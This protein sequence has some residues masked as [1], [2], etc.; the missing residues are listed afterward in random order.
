MNNETMI[1][2]ME[3]SLTTMKAAF[4]QSPMPSLEQRIEKLTKLRVALI[5]H[6]DQICE[7]MN[8]DYGQR[9]EQDTL[10][11]DLLPCIGNIDHTISHLVEWMAPSVRNAGPLLWSS[12]VEVI[13]QPMGVVGI[14]TP[15]NFP[16]MLS[17]GPLI[18]AIA[19]G[20]RAMIKMSEFT[21]N[22]NHVLSTLL[23]TVFEKDEVNVIEGEAGISAHFT[24]LAFDHL[25]FTGSTQ[26]GRLVM[27]AASDNLTPVTLELGGKSPVIIADDVSMELAVE[28]IIYGKSLNNGQV[29]VAPDY[30]LLPEDKKEAFIT[31]YKKQYQTLFARGVHSE[32]LTSIA[33][34]RQFERINGLLNEEITANT[35]IEA[36]HSDSID[37]PQHRLVTHLVINPSLESTIMKEEIFGPLLPILTYQ[38]I[39]DAINI[40]LNKPRPL[41]L[42]LM[43]FDE[44]LQNRIKTT[45]HSGGMCINDC[46]FHLAVDDAPF[47]GIG[48]SGKGNYHGHEGFVTFSH[49]KTVMTS[50]DDHQIK[51]LFSVG[52]NDFKA[53]VMSIIGK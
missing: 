8:R 14:V 9:S 52:N 18:S 51:H 13:Y 2:G 30:V 44:A 39:D 4:S 41:A 34:Q 25:L 49:A 45:V 15:W 21:P 26:V 28:R 7:S 48:E 31:E 50:G 24:G 5:D 16:I 47:G 3:H 38:H 42:Y 22:T 17:V 33:N 46:V 35:R 37:E 53:A 20:N 32:N 11:A 1:E 19:A 40:I 10:I 29:C 6:C 23:S 27:K 12:S 43:S 36:C